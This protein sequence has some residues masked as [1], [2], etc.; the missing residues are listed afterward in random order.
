MMQQPQ[1]R[2]FQPEERGLQQEGRGFQAVVDF[3]R[4]KYGWRL[5]H[6]IGQGGFGV[7]YREVVDGV[8]RAVK[9]SRFS[10]EEMAGNA[11]DVQAAVQR[12][13]EAIELLCQVGNHP[14]VLTLIRYEVVLGHLVTVWELASEGTLLDRLKEH[15]RQ[16]GQCGLP[17][18]QLMPWMEQAA[19]GIEFLNSRGIFHRDIKP[20]NLF[21]VG[22][23][24]K[25][26][27]LG[28]LKLAG[29]S[30]ASQTGMGTVGYLPLEAYPRS[31]NEKGQLH[32]T[33]DVY[34]LAATYVHLRT[35]K[36]PFGTT[37]HEITARQQRGDP[38][39]EGMTA[40]EAEWVRQAL[41]PRPNDRP[42]SAKTF[43]QQLESRLMLGQMT[44]RPAV[45]AQ[46][47]ELP[48]LDAVQVG[49]VQPREH[50][51]TLLPPVPED[52]ARLQGQFLALTEA[53]EQVE[54]ESHPDLRPVR[55]ALEQAEQAFRHAKAELDKLPLPPGV[56][57]ELVQQLYQE[58]RKGDSLPP[59]AF[60]RYCP[61]TN[62]WAF[63]QWLLQAKSVVGSVAD[64]ERKLADLRKQW[65][66]KKEQLLA[67]LQ[68][69]R[70]QVWQQ[71]ERRQREDLRECW[72]HVQRGMASVSEVLPLEV[73][74]R[75]GPELSQRYLGWEETQL[76]TIAEQLWAG[77][78]VETRLLTGH[79][80]AV[81]S[82]S[83]TADGKYVV[84]GSDDKTVR[85]WDLATGQEVRRLTGHQ[86]PVYSVAVT[87]NG[88]QVVSCGGEYNEMEGE[89][90]DDGV[91]LWDLGTGQQV[92]RFT[93]HARAV[94]SVAVTPDGQYVVSGSDDKTVR[95]WEL[96][97]GQQVRRF[98]GH[99][100]PVY[101]VA[102]TPDGK[103]VVSGSGDKTVRVWKLATGKE[104]RRF[105]GHES[106]VRSVAV[107]LD[108]KYI[109]SGSWDKTVRVWK[110]AT[111][112]EVRRFTGHES[113]VRSVAVTPGGKYVVSGSEDKTVRLWDLATGQEVRRFTG[114]ENFVL[115]VAVTPD[116]E[117]VVSGSR[118]K[119]VRLWYIGDLREPAR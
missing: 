117:Y 27:D 24:V 67:K 64:T 31:A 115:A 6:E 71:L 94:E 43:V 118:D 109:V 30:T 112:K 34:G 28:F 38:C 99:A 60:L 75:Y 104:V 80:G 22:G 8:E 110:L 62:R 5:D 66:A 1:G 85:V 77:P 95:L 61:E 16:N 45:V 9:I 14:H 21:L 26:G 12:E 106:G 4:R 49:P 70:Q 81:H 69:Q 25:V 57:R 3:L 65:S 72:S 44:T 48:S 91:R 39:T 33:I 74:V 105:T 51:P 116:G 40:A 111:G 19:E 73:W 41:S 29:L 68:S 35:G 98:T 100:G 47:P 23:Q 53:I 103:Y 10:L 50:R 7:V 92:R 88:R 46:V 2:G 15:Q 55:A 89:W 79:I 97:T 107:T 87:A 93:G 96:A 18:D 101:S 83:V 54:A 58:L 52:L 63:F 78:S 37:P 56:N 17:L 59:S 42:T 108:G 82:L 113:G 13:L 90:I 20:Q 119:T 84:S 102:V 76:L 86:G 32:R 11:N 36:P 114:H